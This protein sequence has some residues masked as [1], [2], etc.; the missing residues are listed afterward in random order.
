LIIPVV[1]LGGTVYN[2]TCWR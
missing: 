2:N 1:V